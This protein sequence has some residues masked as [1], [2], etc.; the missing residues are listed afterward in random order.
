MEDKFF[1]DDEIEKILLLIEKD[2]N[3][4]SELSVSELE[5]LNKYLDEKKHYLTERES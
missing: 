1:I 4:L 2:K 3:K 5:I